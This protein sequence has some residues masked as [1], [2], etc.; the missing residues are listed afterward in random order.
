MYDGM[1]LSDKKKPYA[2]VEQMRE[3]S[4]NIA[5]GRRDYEETFNFQIGVYAKSGSDRTRLSEKLKRALKSEQI[6][7]FDTSGSAPVS[8]GFFVCDITFITPMRV[9][10]S[11]DNTNKHRV[12]FDIEI[13]VYRNNGDEI[14]FTQ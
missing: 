13:S 7:F 14:S 2:V 4:S 12:Y 6:P 9:E 8:V 11:G 10:D 5:S 1:S 3:F